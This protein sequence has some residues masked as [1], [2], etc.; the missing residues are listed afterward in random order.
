MQSE[1]GVG[2][3]R[4]DLPHDQIRYIDKCP[5]DPKKL[6]LSGDTRRVVD[7]RG[8]SLLIFPGSW[9]VNWALENNEGLELSEF[10]RW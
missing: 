5:V 1:Y 2:F 6:V 7:V 10:K 8:N 4:M 3:S 9:A